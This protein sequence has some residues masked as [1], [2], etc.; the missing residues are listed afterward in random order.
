MTALLRKILLSEYTETYTLPYVKEIT[1][2]S[3]MHDVGHP[4]QMLCDN[5]VGLGGEGG[6]RGSQDRGDTCTPVADSYSCMAET[7]TIL[8]SNHPPIKINK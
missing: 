4:K 3:L 1:N 5:L 6:G 2:A 7:I 8:Y